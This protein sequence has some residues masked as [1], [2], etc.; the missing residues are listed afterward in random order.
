MPDQ[1]QTLAEFVNYWT[2]GIG[3]TIG[4]ALLGRIMWH[5]QEVRKDRRRFFGPELLWELPVAGGMGFIG[6]GIAGWLS[7]GQPV[8]TGIVV[9]LAY[10]GPR[11]AEVLFTKWFDRKYGGGNGCN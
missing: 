8:S 9:G 7:L 5:A 11:G 1:Q 3:A 10:L 6:E 4:G 2:G